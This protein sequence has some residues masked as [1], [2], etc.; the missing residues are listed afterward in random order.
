MAPAL[1]QGHGPLTAANGFPSQAEVVINAR[2]WGSPR[3]DQ[4]GPPEDVEPS[5][6]TGKVYCAL[7]G[8]DMRKPEQVD[9]ANPAPA[10]KYG[11]ILERRS[12]TA[13]TTR[14]SGSAGRS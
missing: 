9:K 6:R 7:T 1:V 12:R 5:P 4:D 8:N 13:A 11:H 14:A 2:G 10:N 3:R